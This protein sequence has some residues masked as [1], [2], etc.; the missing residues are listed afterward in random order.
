MT[1]IG[2]SVKQ[3]TVLHIGT[4]N[5]YNNDK[6][7]FIASIKHRIVNMSNRS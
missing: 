1:H 3:V 7:G 4:D 6:S 5:K 2:T